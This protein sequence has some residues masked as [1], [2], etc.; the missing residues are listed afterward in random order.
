MNQALTQF[1]SSVPSK[2]Q[3]VS[4]RNKKLN[5]FASFTESKTPPHH[6]NDFSYHPPKTP[7]TLEQPYNNNNIIYIIYIQNKDLR[8]PKFLFQ[9]P[10]VKL[11]GSERWNT[12]IINDLQRFPP[13][14]YPVLPDISNKNNPRAILKKVMQTPYICKVS[15]I[16][17]M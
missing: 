14:F 17:C 8:H 16:I 5:S 9:V 13:S 1:C 3:N 15:V 11:T 12:F 2:F 10:F 7:R 4:A 6:K